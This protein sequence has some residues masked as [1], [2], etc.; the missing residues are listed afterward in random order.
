M[1]DIVIWGAV[2]VV[3]LAALRLLLGSGRKREESWPFIAQK[4]M[5]EPEQILYFRLTQAFPDHIVLAQVGLSRI[6]GIRKGADRQ[7]W[8]NRISRMSVDFVLC[9]RDASI[10]AAIELDDASHQRPD[11]QAADEKKDRAVAAAGIRMV[12]FHVR[13][14]PTVPR[15]RET[16]VEG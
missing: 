5:S 4:P 9:N 1:R 6:L 2:A 12:R 11:R 7:Y 13:N 3:V 15:L 16:L 14:M 10:V 8:F